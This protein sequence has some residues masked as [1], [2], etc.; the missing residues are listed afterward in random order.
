MNVLLN[1]LFKVKSF[2]ISAARLYD[3][4]IWLRWPSG[5]GKSGGGPVTSEWLYDQT[6]FSNFTQKFAE[7]DGWIKTGKDLLRVDFQQST[8]GTGIPSQGYELDWK[9]FGQPDPNANLDTCRTTDSIF[10]EVGWHKRTGRMWK[11]NF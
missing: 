3:R 11:G 4:S 8:D 10:G 5:S 1:T 6:S 9:C 7:S 2:S